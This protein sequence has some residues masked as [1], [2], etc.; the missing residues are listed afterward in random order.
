M[1]DF[2]S[3]EPA[4]EPARLRW[5]RRL[6]WLSLG[7]LVL[8]FTWI[9][10]T[11]ESGSPI[12][13]IIQCVPLLIFLPGLLRESHR[14]YS[15]LC[16]VVLLYFIPSVTQVV[17]TL[18]YRNAEQPAGHWTDGPILLLTIILFFAAA[19]TSRWLQQW[20]L[21]TQNEVSE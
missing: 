17:M 7:G 19:L 9:N 16:F 21:Q 12:R 2:S 15:W 3:S 20:Q 11:E 14:S 4:L 8:I 18:G 1:S 10:L 13:W 6:T 5:S